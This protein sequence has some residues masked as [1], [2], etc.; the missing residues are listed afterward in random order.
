MIDLKLGDCLEVMKHIPNNSIDLIA[1]DPPY[2]ISKKNNFKTM[3]R[4]GIDFG[5]WDIDFDQLGWIDKIADKVSG[6]GSVVVFNAWRNLGDIASHLEKNGFIVK[7]ILR[8]V[9][10]NPMPRNRDRRYIVDYEF[11]LWAVKKKSKW[12]F[13]RLNESYDR[14]EFRYPIVSG[15]EKTL[16]PTQKPVALMRD[17]ILRHSNEND[18][19]LDP[20]MGS[21]TTGVACSNL[22]RNFI[23]IE[24]DENYFNIARERIENVKP[25]RNDT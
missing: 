5:D 22:N 9:K 17:I 24:L 23:G 10:D 21:G 25:I 11:A 14:P 15:K 18:L 8:W 1:T 20:F 2:E 16:H 19:I 13:N 4:R 3:G 7:D 12:V 6:D